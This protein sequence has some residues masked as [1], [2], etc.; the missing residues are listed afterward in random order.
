[1]SIPLLPLLLVI[2]SSLAW[3][4]FD[5]QRKLLLQEVPSV[6][7]VFLLTLGSAPLFAAWTLIVGASLPSTG[8]WTP[9]LASV[10]LNIFANLFLLE[11]MR[12][13]PLSVSVPLLSLTPVFAALLAIPMLGERPSLAAGAGILMVIAGAVWLNWPRAAKPSQVE[14]P[15]EPAVGHEY[16]RSRHLKGALFV[17]LTSLFWAMTIPL[18]KLA[19]TRAAAPFHGT[20]LNA[21]VAA[22]VLIVL[23]GQRRQRDLAGVRRVPGLF[24]LALVVSCL[25]LGLQLLA[26]PFIFVGT[27]ETLKRGIGNFMSMISGWIFFR[28]T[29]TLPKSLALGLMAVGVGLILS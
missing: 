29:V 25:A 24:A 18:D 1:M 2:A 16:E 27:V 22:G 8:Y 13:V 6:A 15:E 5:L 23:L 9:A 19:L 20:V 21:G 10:L 14:K 7:L 4:G 11:G 28:E 3:A 26:L 17:A 12:I